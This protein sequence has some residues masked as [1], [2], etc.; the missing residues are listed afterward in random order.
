MLC[1]A[2][3]KPGHLARDCAEVECWGCGG[4]GH[5]KAQCPKQYSGTN[6]MP[7]GAGAVMGAAGMS[8][9]QSNAINVQVS[10]A[11]ARQKREA[12]WKFEMFKKN[13]ELEEMTAAL[14]K[15]QKND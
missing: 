2:C 1:Y 11:L 12:D 10:E 14:A 6:T 9:S 15:A 7:V 5:T 13:K 8:R 3:N 4:K